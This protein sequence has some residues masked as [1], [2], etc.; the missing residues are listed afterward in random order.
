MGWMK[1]RPASRRGADKEPKSQ[2]GEDQSTTTTPGANRIGNWIECV[3]RDIHTHIQEGGP[4]TNTKDILDASIDSVRPFHVCQQSRS[5]RNTQRCRNHHP[6]N[7]IPILIRRC[8]HNPILNTK[9]KKI[10]PSPTE[11]IKEEKLL[12]PLPGIFFQKK[13][14]GNKKILAS[15][16][17][18]GWTI[19]VRARAEK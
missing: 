2:K 16:P 14:K 15:F 19:F 11:I 17:F 6:P 12:F 13:K 1:D 3:P 18:F 5:P 7:Q 4:E 8:G 10:W 9:K